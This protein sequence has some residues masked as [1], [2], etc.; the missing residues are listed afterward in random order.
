MLFAGGF[1][2]GLLA[3][4]TLTMVMYVLIWDQIK[5]KEGAAPPLQ[6]KNK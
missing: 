5:Q 4:I 3:G 6:K 2:V 1:I